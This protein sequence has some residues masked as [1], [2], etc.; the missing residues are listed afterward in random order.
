MNS[1]RGLCSKNSSISLSKLPKYLSR[2][3]NSRDYD[4]SW[5]NSG[6]PLKPTQSVL[7]GDLV[8]EISERSINSYSHPYSHTSINKGGKLTKRGITSR[9]EGFGENRT[10]YKRINRNMDVLGILPELEI[11]ATS[12]L[13]TSHH[14]KTRSQTQRGTLGIY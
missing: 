11:K 10:K 12:A 4:S 5:Q 1:R 14:R 2:E 3:P 7:F 8:K 13:M 6:H 9:R